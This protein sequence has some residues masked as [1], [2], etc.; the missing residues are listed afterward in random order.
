MT[1]MRSRHPASQRVVLPNWT[2][3][4]P[5][6]AEAIEEHRRRLLASRYFLVKIA[7]NGD[8]WR[9]RNCNAKHTYLT[10]H[11]IEQPFPG[12][13]GGLYAYYHTVTASGAHL[14]FDPVQQARYD[15]F[16]E[17]F[18]LQQLPDLATGHPML[19]RALATSDNEADIGALSLGV[20]EP[21]TKTEAER[22]AGWIRD[23]GCSR[24]GCC[25]TPYR[26]GG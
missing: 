17:L 25:K 22:F 9:C 10:L 26:L 21:I 5:E 7:G 20:L 15:R 8:V 1:L 13:Y 18:D 19:A 12:V 3:G 4:T 24:P 23:R 14:A 6:Q 11:C 2:I 16:K